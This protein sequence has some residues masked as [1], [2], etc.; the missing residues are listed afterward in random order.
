MFLQE[1]M[2]MTKTRK[3]KAEKQL[4]AAYDA[5]RKKHCNCVQFN[6]LDL[7]NLERDTLALVQQGKTRQDMG[8]GH[9]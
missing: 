7:C 6:M 3:S 1:G 9:V 4:E 2:T 8:R 5:A